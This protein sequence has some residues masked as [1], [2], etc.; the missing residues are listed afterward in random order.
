MTSTTQRYFYLSP[1]CTART[2]LEEAERYFLAGNLNEALAAAQ[3]AW[4]EHPQEPDVFRVLAYIHMMRG[5]YAPAAQAAYQSVRI[6]GDN[7]AS[8]ATLAQVYV[9][10]NM[11]QLA[12]ETL[13]T[14]L[15]RYPDD[16][17]LLILAADVQ[18]RR[19]RDGI[20]VEMAT[21]GLDANPHDG[22]AKA[23]LGVH[24]LRTKHYTAAAS[25]LAEALTVYGQRWD[26]QRDYGI[27]LLLLG[28][29]ATARDA[30]VKSF[31]L[32]PTDPVGKHYL[33]YAM[34]LAIPRHQAHWRLSL[35]Y[36]RTP[37]RAWVIN[38]SGYLSAIAGLIWGL[39]YGYLHSFRAPSIITP[40]I[41]LLGGVALVM[42]TTPA[43][44]MR[45][46][47]GAHFDALLAREIEA[48]GGE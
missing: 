7:V 1:T 26:Y 6:D 33:L 30:L 23:L 20:A 32:N 38:I 37:V 25:L 5:E 47:R 17:T 4:R 28:E 3:Q 14:A 36:Y 15:Q 2:R 46:R 29:Y 31:R 45:G 41:L 8:F 48:L 10:F 21:R 24:H 19:G 35:F 9:T 27:A 18:F 44:L 13:N 34:R 16:A 11:L 40:T 39:V 22:Y 43:L 42:L 12:E